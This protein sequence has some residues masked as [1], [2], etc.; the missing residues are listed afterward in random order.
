MIIDATFSGNH[1][2][3]ENH[4]LHAW[5]GFKQAEFIRIMIN[6]C[7]GKSEYSNDRLTC[8]MEMIRH[9]NGGGGQ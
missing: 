3:V 8:R 7:Q 9:R 5:T 4:N 2:P 1:R 6:W